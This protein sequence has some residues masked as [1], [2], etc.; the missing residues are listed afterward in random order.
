[1]SVFDP[2]G[3]SIRSERYDPTD[4]GLYPVRGMAPEVLTLGGKESRLLRLSSRSASKLSAK[5]VGKDATKQIDQV[6]LAVHRDGRREVKIVATLPREEQVEVGAP[7]GT[8]AVV[9]PLT[10]RP[11]MAL[12]RDD[13]RVCAGHQAASELLCVTPDG[14]RVGI[15]W[16]SQPRTVRPDDAAVAR[17][18]DRTIEAY[19]GKLSARDVQA[20]LAAVPTPAFHPAFDQ[21]VFDALG[22][23]WIGMGPSPRGGE[24]DCLIFGPDLR[25]VGRLAIPTMTIAEIGADY[26][27]GIRRDSLGAD[28]VVAFALAR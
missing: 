6:G 28:E 1:V 24:S 13:D 15:R 16:T 10:A 20:M 18:R 9:P 4:A 11:T 23:L 5:S 3:E 25:V 27:L 12:G 7:W 17:W 2:G 22:Y 8:T 21:L 14:E 19:G 26:V